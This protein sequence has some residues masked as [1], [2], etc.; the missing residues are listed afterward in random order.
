M[1]TTQKFVGCFFQVKCRQCSFSSNK[2]DPFLDLSLE[3]LKANSLQ[4]ALANFTTAELLDGG[5]K[6]YH[7]QRCKQKV[8][9]LKQLTIHKAPYVLAIHLKRFYAY[10]P[11]KKIKKNVEFDSALDLKPFVSGSYVSKQWSIFLVICILTCKIK[12]KI[13]FEI[14]NL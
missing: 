1:T 2:F 4:K 10:D 5:E 8:Q 11:H 14:F 13:L 7:C 6:Q 3:I 9:A 12:I